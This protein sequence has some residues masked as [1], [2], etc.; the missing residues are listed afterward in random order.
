MMAMFFLRNITPLLGHVADQ[1]IF[2]S[3]SPILPG[4]E[5]MGSNIDR[6]IIDVDERWVSV[7]IGQQTCQDGGS[8]RTSIMCQQMQ[9]HDCKHCILFW[10][11][12]SGE[13]WIF[14]IIL[15]NLLDLSLSRMGIRELAAPQSSLLV[16]NSML[17]QAM[18]CCSFSICR[19]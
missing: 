10:V 11:L 9:Q 2:V 15:T 3:T 13:T 4:P 7:D 1:T 18:T 14:Q 17:R 8:P 16:L 19:A 5:V 6:T 12:L